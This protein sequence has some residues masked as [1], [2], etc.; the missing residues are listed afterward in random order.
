M[1]YVAVK[2]QSNTPFD[3]SVS[4]TL[5]GDWKAV[6]EARPLALAPGETARL[7]FASEG[8]VND[9][10]NRYPVEVT[11]SGSDRKITHEQEVFCASAPYFKPEIDGN[12][13]EWKDAIPVSFSTG[14]KTTTVRTYWN[15]RTFS[16]LVSVEEDAL[17]LPGK[18]TKFDAVQFALAPQ[19]ATT[20]T[21]PEEETE[22]FE[23]LLTSGKWLGSGKV[24]QLA[25]PGM[26]LA[27]AVTV[28]SLAGLEIADA[29]L[30]VS[31]EGR[32]TH[33]ECSIPFAPMRRKIR[34]SEGREFYF[35][36]VVHDPDGTGLR[37]LG[38]AAGMWPCQRK[39]FSW[40]RFRGDSFAEKASFDSKTPWG[41]CSSKY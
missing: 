34:P 35:S 8:G 38:A 14:G 26:K 32:T 33:Y 25:E 12:I 30:S 29:T 21:S 1:V 13:D 41:L 3:G 19:G 27:E 15:R 40:C 6:P 10:S 4:V 37:E 5:P 18:A 28:R 7:G 24:L 2:N 20:G 17:Q 11:V 31:R 9:A 36:V 16:L 39:P 23:F 22:R